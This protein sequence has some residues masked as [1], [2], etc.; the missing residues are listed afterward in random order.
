MLHFSSQT[1]FKLP[2]EL[3]YNNINESLTKEPYNKYVL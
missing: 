2:N 3:I 1:H